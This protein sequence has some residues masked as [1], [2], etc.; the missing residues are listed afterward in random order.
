MTEVN[1]SVIDA[2]ARGWTTT[3]VALIVEEGVVKLP[4]TGDPV[5]QSSL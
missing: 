4:V 2:A 3:P 5:L 1:I